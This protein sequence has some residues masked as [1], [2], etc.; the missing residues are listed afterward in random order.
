MGCM[1]TL[2]K[3][4]FASTRRFHAPGVAQENPYWIKSV[5]NR[6]GATCRNNNHFERPSILNRQT[7]RQTNGRYQTHYLP[8]FAVDNDWVTCGAL[9][10][11]DR[12]M[13]GA[14]KWLRACAL[15]WHP[16][17]SAICHLN[18]TICQHF[19]VKC[20]N[21]SSWTHIQISWSYPTMSSNFRQ[22]QR[23][24]FGVNYNQKA[25]KVFISIPSFLGCIQI[26]P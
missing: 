15:F 16:K 24:K 9:S 19:S 13:Y 20:W 12:Y 4:I 2:S 5:I 18:V 17:D 22:G 7:D 14:V 26:V 3:K 25:C 8:C 23:T 1:Y 21:A 10:E 11:L 6:D